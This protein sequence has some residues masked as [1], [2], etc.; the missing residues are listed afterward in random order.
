MQEYVPGLKLSPIGKESPAQTQSQLKLIELSIIVLYQVNHALLNKV[1]RQGMGK[2]VRV[3]PQAQGETS[4]KMVNWNC[5]LYNSR[6][7]NNTMH[8]T[9]SLFSDG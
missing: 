7:K 8:S 5:V 4:G 9:M 6:N 2:V 3:L 1:L